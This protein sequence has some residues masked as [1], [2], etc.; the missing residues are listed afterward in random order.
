MAFVLGGRSI[1]LAN[2][3]GVRVGVDLSWFL[4]LFLIIWLLSGAFRGAFPR[5]GEVLPF[6][7]A[8]I[9]ALLFFASVVVHELG[10]A[11]V[12]RRNGIEIAGIDL[13]LFGGL[14]RMRSDARSAG[15]D[16][17]VAAAGPLVT[18]LVGLACAAGVLI[19]AGEG[20]FT[21]ALALRPAANPTAGGVAA[22]VLGYL[23]GINLLLLLF[24]LLPGLP[25]DG[26]RIARAIAWKVTGDRARATRIAAGL[27]RGFAIVLIGLG[28]FWALTGNLTGG[29]WLVLI[30]YVMSQA[31]R[32]AVVQSDLTAGIERLSVEDVMDAEPVA[33][34]AEASLEQAYEERFLR[35]GWDWFPV[36]DQG[37]RFA[38]LLARKDIEAVPEGARSERRVAE[39]VPPGSD[40]AYRVRTDDPLETL[41]GSEALRRLG[42][43]V[44]VDAEGTLR[45]VLTLDHV[46]RALRPAA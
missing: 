14:A 41:L 12:A 31:A 15:V 30:G 45:G 26:G 39:L 33:V 10:H 38:G 16:F 22:A 42:A 3:L 28:V 6:A 7:L 35:Y 11:V 32:A 29:I 36:V 23:A 5:A 44:A 18:L 2:V 24:N 40:E 1:K 13:W 37:G 46:Q 43:V 25:L 34:P 9:T 8:V 17:R 4:V 20:G 27:G 19:L 21:D